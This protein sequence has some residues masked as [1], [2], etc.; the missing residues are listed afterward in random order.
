MGTN[1]Y[2]D[3]RES[4][5]CPTCGQYV[6]REGFH[7][8]KSS[9]GWAL[10]LHV[11][12]NKG[13]NNVEDMLKYI[14]DKVIHNEYGDIVTLD[15]FISTAF[16]RKR[17][18]PDNWDKMI[19]WDYNSFGYNRKRDDVTSPNYQPKYDINT[20]YKDDNYYLMRHGVDGKHCIGKSEKHPIDYITGEFS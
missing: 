6:E 17:E 10:S 3:Y 11:Y 12:P 15:E 18:K 7:I 20:S 16:D 14:K 13:I 1:F 19:A 8:A 9:F 2:L 5:D 4:H